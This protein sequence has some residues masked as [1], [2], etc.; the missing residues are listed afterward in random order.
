MVSIQSRVTR[1]EEATGINKDIRYRVYACLAPIEGKK[2]AKD[3]RYYLIWKE[4]GGEW[5]EDVDPCSE[6]GKRILKQ[7]IEAN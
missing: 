1:L 4:R 3:G 6:E 5:L 2:P 7:V